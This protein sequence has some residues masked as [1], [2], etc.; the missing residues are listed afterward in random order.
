MKTLLWLFLIFLWIG[1]VS[2]QTAP[3]SNPA[4]GDA[5]KLSPY[6]PWA[7]VKINLLIPGTSGPPYVKS[8][9]VEVPARR[10]FY[11]RYDSYL[12]IDD[13][14]TQKTYILNGYDVLPFHKNGIEEFYISQDSGPVFCWV[15]PGAIMFG[16]TYVELP[17]APGSMAKAIAQFEA[18]YDRDK[19][20]KFNREM[21]FEKF[22]AIDLKAAAPIF[23]FD[24]V[25][26]PG[27]TT[28][29]PDIESLDLM[30][31]ILHMNVRNPMTKIPATFWIDLKARKVIESVVDGQQMDLTTGKPFAV[32]L[33]K[34]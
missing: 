17:T 18:E 12:A 26:A 24:D 9:M 2:A 5:A 23:Y 6:S 22:S 31:G 30:D 15:N 11:T 13:P 28:L 10:A 32:P 29:P 8:K 19:L 20:D 27:C 25:P 1:A 4:A 14:Y 7:D 21:I 34:N 33:S 3:S 16:W